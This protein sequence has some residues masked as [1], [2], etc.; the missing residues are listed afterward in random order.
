MDREQRGVESMVSELEDRTRNVLTKLNNINEALA[1]DPQGANKADG[2]HSS[3]LCPRLSRVCDT[4]EQAE[5]VATA[6]EDKLGL[7]KTDCDAPKQM[8][9]SPRRDQS[10]MA[11]EPQRVR[12]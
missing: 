9:G 8:M 5:I 10:E 7:R 11:G 2:P 3:S 4:V 1:P 6:I 12:R